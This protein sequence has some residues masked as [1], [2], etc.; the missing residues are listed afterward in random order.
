MRVVARGDALL[1]PSV[2][3]AVIAAFT[4]GGPAAAPRS[5]RAA[6]SSA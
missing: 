6:E 4:D 2:T 1:S 5:P 3:R